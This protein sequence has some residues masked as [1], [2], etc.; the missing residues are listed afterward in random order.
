M[1]QGHA[2]LK[3]LG[4]STSALD[5]LVAAARKAGAFGAK[6]TGGGMGGAMVALAPP[7]LD[8]SSVLN[9]AGASEVIAS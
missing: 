4:V 8:L 6:L 2:L 1:D 3:E 7:D 9:A 5:R